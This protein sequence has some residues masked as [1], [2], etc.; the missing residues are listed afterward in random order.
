M[1]FNILAAKLYIAPTKVMDGRGILLGLAD[2]CNIFGPP[3]VVNEV[4]KQ[5]LVLAMSKASLSTQATKNIIY[6]QP[7]ARAAW[8]TY[9]EENPRCADSIV[10]FIHE[11]HDGRLPPAEDSEDF[12]DPMAES[13]WPENDGINILGTHYGSPAFVETYLHTKLIKHKEVLSFIRDVAKMGFPREARKM[14]TGSTVPRL[15]HI[16]KSVP[17]DQT[18]EPWM[19]EVDRAHLSTWMGCVG[20]SSLHDDMT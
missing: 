6:V 18:S 9:L 12:C 15:T 3:E 8:L 17:K 11:I 4:I 14:L 2:D 19:E 5:L 13:T 1:F 10:F 16:L 7:S 20:S